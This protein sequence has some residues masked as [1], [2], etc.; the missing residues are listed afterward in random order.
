MAFNY[1]DQRHYYF[2]EK[3]II[4]WDLVKPLVHII[5]GHYMETYC[6]LPI[7]AGY[8]WSALM[9]LLTLV[10]KKMAREGKSPDEQLEPGD[11]E[12]MKPSLQVSL[13]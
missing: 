4:S 8:V 1:K 3:Y 5:A 2:L 13:N 10:R 7:I 12:E 9:L 11:P 6:L